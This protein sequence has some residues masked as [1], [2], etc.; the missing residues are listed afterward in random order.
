MTCYWEVSSGESLHSFF[1]CLDIG[2]ATCPADLARSS[3]DVGG[4][5]ELCCSGKVRLVAGLLLPWLCAEPGIHEIFVCLSFG[6]VKGNVDTTLP[7]GWSFWDGFSEHF[8]KSRGVIL[9]KAVTQ[10]LPFPS[11]AFVQMFSPADGHLSFEVLL[12]AVLME[13]FSC[14][15]WIPVVLLPPALMISPLIGEVCILIAC[16]EFINYFSAL[17]WLN[18]FFLNT[19]WWV[20]KSAVCCW[21]VLSSRNFKLA[22]LLGI[23][24]GLYCWEPGGTSRNW[25]VFKL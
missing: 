8:I 1:S 18:F 11:Q 4:G 12:T 22:Q 16:Q 2:L 13:A 15:E 5:E 10:L 20:L 19:D 21:R 6:W 24:K 25:S 23:N 3:Q 7:L 9:Y 14:H 17:A